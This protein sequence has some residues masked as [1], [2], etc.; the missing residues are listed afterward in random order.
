MPEEFKSSVSPFKLRYQCFITLLRFLFELLSAL[1]V[2]LSIERS[3]QCCVDTWASLL[4]HYSLSLYTQTCDRT[5]TAWRNAVCDLYQS[6]CSE[7]I[8]Y[9]T[10][11]WNHSRKNI[12]CHQHKK[13]QVFAQFWHNHFPGATVVVYS[14]DWQT[15]YSVRRYCV[16]QTRIWVKFKL[17]LAYSSYC[18][19]HLLL[20]SPNHHVVVKDQGRIDFIGKVFGAMVR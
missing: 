7:N 3:L 10:I 1:V 19:R 2:K 5:S 20:P 6:R 15:L 17:T 18:D 14:D 11:W 8:R 16:R 12:V 9:Y 4:N 13:L